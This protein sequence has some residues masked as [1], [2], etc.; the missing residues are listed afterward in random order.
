[1]WSLVFKPSETRWSINR[2]L[3][4]SFHLAGENPWFSGP[5]Y[6]SQKNL[7]S[8][9]ARGADVS[10][11]FSRSNR[12]TPWYFVRSVKSKNT[13]TSGRCQKKKQEE[14]KWWKPNISKYDTNDLWWDTD[15]HHKTHPNLAMSDDVFCCQR[16]LKETAE[17]SAQRNSRKSLKSVPGMGAQ[18]N[19]WPFP[20]KFGSCSSASQTFKWQFYHILYGQNWVEKNIKLTKRRT[21]ET[22]VTEIWWPINYTNFWSRSSRHPQF[23]LVFERRWCRR[24]I[25][26]EHRGWEATSAHVPW[27]L[28]A[29]WS[30]ALA[31][32]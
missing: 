32:F 8:G 15:I 22:W 3:G 18:C 14:R 31:V 7:S 26:P 10:V 23:L 24:F 21:L 25:Q 29:G 1:M 19:T 6:I 11:C 12:T 13:Q 20:L 2:T 16:W 9:L 17:A 28:S 27:I 5:S 30:L 4:S